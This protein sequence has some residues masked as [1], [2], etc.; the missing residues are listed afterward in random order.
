MSVMDP[1]NEGGWAGLMKELLGWACRRVTPGPFL[2]GQRCRPGTRPPQRGVTRS[3]AAPRYFSRH[4]GEV[5]VSP[6]GGLYHPGVSW[7]P[8]GE[9]RRVSLACGTPWAVGTA[10]VG[11][12]WGESHEA[13]VNSHRCLLLISGF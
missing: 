9:R 6:Q 4:R 13:P 11:L 12:G 1:A 7:D 10:C 3:M 2:S 5:W 8:L